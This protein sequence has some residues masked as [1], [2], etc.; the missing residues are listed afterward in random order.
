M[1]QKTVTPF[2]EAIEMVESLPLE[3]QEELIDLIHRRLVER[4]RVEIARHAQETLQAVKE[5]QAQYGGFED[6]RQDL[7]EDELPNRAES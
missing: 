1:R 2:Q 3:V 7:V 6:L 5:G 4:R